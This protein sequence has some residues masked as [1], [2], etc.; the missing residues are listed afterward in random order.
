MHAAGKGATLWRVTNRIRYVIAL[1]VADRVGILRDLT[2]SVA[3]L[4]GNI[5][6][7]RQTVVNGYFTVTLTAEFPRARAAEKV[8][9]AI[10]ENFTGEEAWVVVRPWVPGP[11]VHGAADGDAYVVTLTGPDRP[12]VLKAVTTFFASKGINIEDWTV[13][14]DR[15]GATQVGELTVPRHLD[16]PQVQA[17]LRQALAKL[18]QTAC[19]QQVN[20]FRATNEIGPIKPLLGDAPHA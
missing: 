19:L 4:G 8:R 12:G 11:P 5:D 16:V 20:I 1:L 13:A 9:E 2:S 3:R 10:A 6:G 15:A 14:F 18:E 17:E 7:I